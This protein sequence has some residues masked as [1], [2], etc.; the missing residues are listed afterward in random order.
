M[1]LDQP[2]G[3]NHAPLAEPYTVAKIFKNRQQTEI[4]HI[5]LSTYEQHNL[6]NVR[7]FTTGSDGIDRATVKGISMSVRKLPQ[8]ARALAKAEAKARELGLIAAEPGQ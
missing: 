6:I 5:S 3:Q 8:L 1:A 2:P 4:V 7:I